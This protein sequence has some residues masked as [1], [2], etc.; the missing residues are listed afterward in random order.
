MK[1]ILLVFIRNP[2]LGKVKTR[3]ARTLG[4][5]EALR[6]YHILLKKTRATALACKAERWLF[7]SDFITEND[8]W[9][10]SDFQKK[11]QHTG[12]LG[13]RMDEA[14]KMAF[15][16]GAEKVAII[17]SD[18]PDLTGELLQQAFD[19]LDS[20]DFVVGPASD[21]GYYLIGMKALEPSV[22][23]GIQWSTET[24][25]EKTLEKIR[26]TGK[27]CALLPMLLDVDT[28]EDWRRWRWDGTYFTIS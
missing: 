11:I 12:D 26:V 21:G 13:E 8:E 22:F 16:A 19:L 2:Q 14:F 7:Y 20:T 1:N 24:V 4:D 10:R 25:R 6:I 27:S 18:C 15:G 5:E 9:L 23:Q 28:E 3:L 17:G